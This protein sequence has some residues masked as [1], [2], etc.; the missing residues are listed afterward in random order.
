VQ[1]LWAVTYGNGTFVAA[2]EQ[3]T[4]L[5]SGRPPEFKLTAIG[6]G[7]AGFQ[8]MV[9]GEPNVPYR[10]QASTNLA[11]PNWIDLLMFT[12]SQPAATLTDPTAPAFSRRF[13]QVV[14]P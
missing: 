6:F 1:T 12:N 13:Y 11:T 2:G 10:L 5:Q 8:L 14:S 3:A 4:I 7:A 9:V